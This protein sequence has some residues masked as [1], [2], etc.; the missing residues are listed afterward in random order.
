[1][2]KSVLATLLC[3]TILH[4]E[5][6]RGQ[7]SLPDRAGPPEPTDRR[8]QR[9][10]QTQG[11]PCYSWET[12]V[13]GS[14]FDVESRTCQ[15]NRYP[16]GEKC[17]WYFDVDNC[18]PSITCEVLDI[19]G[20]TRKCRGDRLTVETDHSKTPICGKKKK[21]KSFTATQATAYFDINFRTNRKEEGSGFRCSVSCSGDSTTPTPP[22][23]SECKCGVPNRGNKIVGGVETLIHEY[24]WQAGLADPGEDIPFCGGA[25]ISS[26]TIITAAHC[27]IDESVSSFEVL[28]AD[29]DVSID[30]GQERIKVCNKTEHPNYNGNTQ[31]HDLSIL[32]LC[33]P[34]TFRKDASPVCL[35]SQSG[36]SYDGMVSTVTGWGTNSSGTLFQPNELMKV[37][38]TTIDN[39]ECN[40][41][42]SGG[43]TDS[44]I[45]AKGEGKDACQGDSGGPLITKEP[46][47]YYSLIGMVS[48]GIGCANPLYP[49]VY[50]RV[51]EDLDWIK[52][53]IK[54]TTCSTPMK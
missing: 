11:L 21:N 24:P 18:T 28:I 23:S 3:L 38:V 14:S 37:D 2:Q 52:E 6:I 35:P 7:G 10:P 8:R 43:I 32:T 33:T 49:G 42:Y 4:L 34:I 17:V 27:T 9:C 26:D 19:R 46:G 25:I 50:A 45:C 29:H 5:V 12:L 39:T 40:T 41:A 31:D 1:M 13:P 44:M 53:N 15:N 54:G 20:K 48:W 16:K 47:D 30:D 51:T 36:P 22:P